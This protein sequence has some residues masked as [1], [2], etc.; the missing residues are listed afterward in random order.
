MI[1][2]LRNVIELNSLIIPLWLTPL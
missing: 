1:L 2:Q